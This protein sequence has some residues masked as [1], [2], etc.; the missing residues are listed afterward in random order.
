MMPS[1]QPI[2]DPNDEEVVA[3][4]KLLEALT[5][6]STKVGEIL[7]RLGVG[8]APF[9]LTVG[10]MGVVLYSSNVCPATQYELATC[11]VDLMEE[12]DEDAASSRSLH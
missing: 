7:S 2:L 8:N 5:E 1:P 3:N 6:A 12:D 10:G 11:V 4:D 9:M